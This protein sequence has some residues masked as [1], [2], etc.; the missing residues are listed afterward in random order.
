MPINQLIQP[1]LFGGYDFM[2]INSLSL[3]I[4]GLNIFMGNGLPGM[5]QIQ[6]M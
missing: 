6:R 1:S 3:S 2:D 4:S 5:F